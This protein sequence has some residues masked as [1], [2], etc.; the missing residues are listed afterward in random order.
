MKQAFFFLSL[1]VALLCGTFGSADESKGKYEFKIET[2][3]PQPAMAIRFKV[4][5][6]PEKISAKFAEA[7]TALFTHV[8]ANGA[9]PAGQPFG[10]Y[11]AVKDNELDIE[12][13]IPVAKAIDGKGDIKA[14]ELPGGK[15]ITTVHT[16][17][18]EKLAG[19]HEALQKWV[20]QKSYKPTGAVWE[21]Y[22]TDPGKEKDPNKW[23]TKLFL[24]IAE[25]A[26]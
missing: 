1:S 6:D 22:V 2:I 4:A 19:A 7:F 25:P 17:P 23:Q 11:H 21:V 10:R 26:K 16:G 13:G 15:V 12:A 3:K 24:P 14:I 18:Y 9:Q 20:E 8:I 5:P